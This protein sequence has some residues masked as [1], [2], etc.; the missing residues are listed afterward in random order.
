[1]ISKK[2]LARAVNALTRIQPKPAII[3][4]GGGWD[5][6]TPP[7]FMP[8]GYARAAQN[9]E[10][11]VNGGY[12]RVLGYERYD[13]RSLPSDATYSII[14]ITLTGSIAAGD[15]VTGVTSA[16]SAVVIAVASGYIAVT[17]VSGTF[18]SGET[19]NVSG[20]PQATTTSAAQA[21]AASSTL[22]NAQY[23]NLAADEYRDDISAPTGSGSSLGGVRFG[24]V[25]YCW[26]NNAGGTAAELWKSSSSGWTAVTLFNEISFT[27]GGLTA[28]A[29]GS[30][31]TR[32]ANTATIKRV[33]LTSG[34]WAAGTAAGRLIVTTPTPGDFTAGAA[35]VGA[36]NL[37]LSGAQTAITFAASGRF[38]HI[39]ANFGGSPNTNRIYGCDGVN[40]GFEFDGTVLVPI[41]TGMT[42]D[43]PTHVYAHK[44]QLF[45]SFIGSVQ[46]SGPGTPYVWSVIT[47]ASEI[48]MGDTVNGFM[49][50]PG[51]ESVGALAI[52]TRNQT[53]ILYGTGVSNWQ[54][55]PYRSELG[56]YA[57]T[58]QDIG[59]T[60]FLDDQGVT[61]L[62]TAQAFGNFAHDSVTARVKTWLSQQRSKAVE[63]C[64]VRD[65]SQYRLFF[66][67][68][69]ALYLTFAGKKIVGSMPV[70]FP[71][72]VTW[73]YSSEE[74]DGTET[75]FF[76]ST[77]GMVYQ[78]DKGTS[79]DG[80]DIEHYLYMA[81]D[82]LKA[83]R[84]LKRYYDCA[85]EIS[86][87]GYATLNFAYLLGYSSTDIAQPAIQTA[88]TSFAPGAWDVS[89]AVWD[90]GFWDGQ[91]LLPSA[92][93]MSG[94]A[95]N[96]SLV[97]SGSSD[98]YQSIKL[99]GAVVHYV[100]RREK[101]G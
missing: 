93:D 76:G 82:F 86:G 91:T 68:G 26:R 30:T 38:K 1:M 47:G 20:S 60:M 98:F 65:K 43:T 59:M 84:L 56:A 21:E 67:D 3:A 12:S 87:N 90:V 61:T 62:Q 6:I 63:S 41:T 77:N 51:S 97:F 79:F 50:Q 101:R 88:T 92:F 14:S 9:W 46:H 72:A 53:S 58:I 81:W 27:A 16:A 8:S 25:L 10:C 35:T 4:F 11:D 66:S 13:G 36:I 80:A 49:A 55:I 28:P 34:T 57:H 31:L 95:E 45:F 39:V 94:E 73:A 40:R 69:Y 64:V 22:L 5:Q 32:G 83:P 2:A 96:V 37:T 24:G 54:L 89:G 15:T 52:F 71:N 70:V 17:K 19:L 18:V 48:G 44:L 23:F 75:I 74:S 33:V 78:M 100:A 99:S 7:L 42:T 29:E 85:L